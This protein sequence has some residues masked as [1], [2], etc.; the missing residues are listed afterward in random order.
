MKK[1]VQIST[2]LFIALFTVFFLS[3]CGDSKKRR[4]FSGEYTETGTINV[5]CDES[6]SF[7]LDTVFQWYR[8]RYDKVELNVNYVNARN[9]MAQLLSGQTNV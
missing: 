5:F 3:N 6:Y 1:I 2:I 8:E 9:A 7:I 4:P